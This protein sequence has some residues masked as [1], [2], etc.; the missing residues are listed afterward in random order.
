MTRLRALR[1]SKDLARRGLLARVESRGDTDL[2][3]GESAKF[4]AITSDIKDIDGQIREAEAENIR[5][6]RDNPDVQA[7]LRATTTPTDDWAARAFQSIK[8]LGGDEKRAYVAS[9]SVDVPRLISPSVTAIARP[10]RLIDLLVNRNTLES[11]AFEYFRQTVRTNNADTVADLG[12]KP[13]SVFTVVPVQDR[14]RVIAHLSEPVP[15]RLFQDARDVVEWLRSEMVAGVLDAVESQVIA[16]GGTGED[17]TGILTIGGTTAVPFATDVV[18][19]L[20]RAVTALQ[21]K[22]ETPNA[23]IVHPDDAEAIDLTK[24]ATGGVGFL[25][26]GYTNRNTGSDNVFGEGITRVISNSVPAGT[27]ILADWSKA[28]LE[29]REDVRLDIDTSGDNFAINAATFRAETRV[30]LAHL[31]PSAFA[32]VDLTSGT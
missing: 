20:R 32:I 13:T 17:L 30:G 28:R 10:S 25:V 16:G 14:A 1:E 18:T 6:G 23:W 15:I 7:V 3:D 21:K 31:R 9:G 5:A 12:T 22:G 4:A 11:N 2:T 8:R 27:A 24:E 29:V 26:D 19:T